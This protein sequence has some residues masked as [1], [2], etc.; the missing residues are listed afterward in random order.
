VHYTGRLENGEAFGDSKDGKPLEF[1]LG[2]GGVIPGFERGIIGMK[3]GEIKTITVPP[4][5]AYGPRHGELLLD[6]EKSKFPE[7][8]TGYGEED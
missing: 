7:N 6:V 2:S 8:S 4:E 1:P 3:A 5:E